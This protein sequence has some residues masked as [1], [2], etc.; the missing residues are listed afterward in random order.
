MQGVSP[1]GVRLFEQPSCEAVA[2]GIELAPGL[3]NTSEDPPDSCLRLAI[4]AQA[5]PSYLE[6]QSTVPF[7]EGRQGI[8]ATG[9]QRIHQFCIGECSKPTGGTN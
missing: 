1:D 9:A 7:E 2:V 5:S 6:D 8:V 4:T 3:K